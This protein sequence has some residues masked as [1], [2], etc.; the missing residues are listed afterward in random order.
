MLPF[1]SRSSIEAPSITSRRFTR[2]R[3]I[4]SGLMNA[5]PEVEGEWP[6]AP[7]PGEATSMM[8]GHRLVVVLHED[9]GGTE[10][11]MLSLLKKSPTIWLRC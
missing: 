5:G 2:Y 9:Y 10:H 3:T 11:E 4:K 6:L 8:E 7:S 1:L